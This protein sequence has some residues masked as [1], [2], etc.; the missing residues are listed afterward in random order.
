MAADATLYSASC[1]KTTYKEANTLRPEK[2]VDIWQTLFSYEFNWKNI[3]VFQS[4]LTFVLKIRI[5]TKWLVDWI[6]L[7]ETVMAGFTVS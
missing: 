6:V 3:F 5:D 2:M 1:L 7:Y 4:W